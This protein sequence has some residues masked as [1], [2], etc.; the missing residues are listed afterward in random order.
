MTN[1]IKNNN[2]QHN[3]GIEHYPKFDNIFSLSRGNKYP[4]TVVPVILRGGKKQRAIMIAILTF[5]WD[6][7]ANCSM[8]KIK[9]TK[10]YEHKM[11]SNKAE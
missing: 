11:R 8:I 4:L 10:H 7:G 9:H 6:S 1:N 3:Y 2:N 5:L